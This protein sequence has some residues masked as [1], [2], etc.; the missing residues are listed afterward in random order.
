MSF[1]AR[2]A[3]VPRLAFALALGGG[4]LLVSA[5]S[6]DPSVGGGEPA[7]SSTPTGGTATA[8]A[9]ASAAPSAGNGLAVGD[10][11]PDFTLAASD[12]KDHKLSDH[13]GKEAVVIAWFPKAFTGGCTAECKSIASSS[14]IL[15]TYDV[16]YFMASVDDVETNTRFAKEQVADYPILADPSKAV[17]KAYGVIRLDR[18]ADQQMAAR[19]TFY[20]GPDGRISAIDK[21]PTTATAGEVMVKRLTELGV[22]KR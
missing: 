14:A 15:K 8:A 10:M 9:G 1:A 21:S 17:A 16:A 5:C 11:A 19:W 7:K 22:K 3:F 6:K 12:G 4:L 2:S 18:P 13:R 20:I